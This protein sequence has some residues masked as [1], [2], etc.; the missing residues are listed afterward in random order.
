MVMVFWDAIS[1]IYRR[2]IEMKSCSYTVCSKEERVWLPSNDQR[3]GSVEKHSWCTTCGV[4]QNI[5]DDRSKN[6]GYWMNKLSFVVS[7]LELT[8]CQKRL[9]AKEIES[10]EY[11]CDTFSAFGSCQKELFIKT[12]SKYCDTSKIDFDLILK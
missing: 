2:V 5:S 11:F 4:V 7:E 6:S 10:I 12:V 3:Y 1:I 8:Q 9:I